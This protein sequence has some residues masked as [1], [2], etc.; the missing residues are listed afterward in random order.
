MDSR[1]TLLLPLWR[2]RYLLVAAALLG[3]FGGILLGVGRPNSYRS[4][5]KLMIRAGAREQVTPEMSVTGNAGGFG[6]GGHNVVLD[7]MHLLDAPEVYEDAARLVTPAELL[8]AYDP[9]LRDDADTSWLLSLFHRGQS[10]WFQRA[11]TDADF[12]GHALDLCPQCVHVASLALARNLSLVAEPGSDV[13][14]VSYTAHDGELARKVVAAFLEA[15][16]AH[17]RKIY[18]TNT[19]LEFLDTQLGDSLRDL[20]TIENE[21]T[22]FKTESGV[23]DFE[24]QQRTL[25]AGIHELEGL[26]AQDQLHLEELRGRI[27][28][29]KEEVPTLPATL[30]EPTEHNLQANPNRATIKQRIFTLEDSLAAVD[31]R[32]SGTTHER[33]LE[34]ASISQAIER[35]RAELGQQPEFVDA[36]PSI[37]KVPN[38][39]RDRLTQQLDDASAELAALEASSAK[40]S[41]SLEDMR[42]K[43]HTMSQCEA[44]FHALQDAMV[45]ARG[46]YEGFRS[47]HE[48]ASLMGSMDQLDFSN[49][50]VIQAATLPSEK[51]GPL[52]GKLVLIGLLLGLIAGGGLAFARNL[53]DHRL[54]DAHDAEQLL[55]RPVLGLLYSPG[56]ARGPWHLRRGKVG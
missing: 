25:I 31:R 55:G 18:E 3:A 13:I 29:L 32:E 15:S 34:R 42:A 23:Y 5:G 48:R 30:E 20:T 9:G 12:P 35:A 2:G 22:N 1:R 17:H 47:A 10:W 27:K 46:R 40:R 14:T 33:E 52:R 53:L 50:R 43:L 8:R 39:R 37:R 38:T 54:H 45:Q 19:T 56:S 44:K 21:F 6:A 49:L 4:V 41:Q 16:I 28:V 7:E 36:G 26:T 11:A 51:E 24:N